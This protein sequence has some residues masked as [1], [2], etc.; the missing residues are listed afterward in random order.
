MSLR[1]SST[2]VAGL[3][4]AGL[5]IG[6]A[7]EGDASATEAGRN[8][9][10]SGLNGTMVGN[11]PPP[12]FY[13][14]NEFIYQHASRFNDSQGNKL[15]PDFSV[16]AAGYAP[17]FL[18]NSGAKLFGGDVAIQVIQPFLYTEVKNPS[19][20]PFV[21][22]TP[23]FGSDN[24]FALGDLFLTPVIGWHANNF[25]WAVGMD[26]VLPTGDYDKDRL[27]NAGQ[28][29][30]TL[31][32][33]IAFTY[34]PIEPLELST[35]LTWDH[36]FENNATEYASG[37]AFLVDYAANYYVPTSIGQIAPGL[38]GY[39]FKQVEDDQI[40]GVKF[41]DGFRGQ[42]FAIGP[43]V[44]LKHAS[45]AIGELKFQKEFEVE[46]RPAGERIFARLL[47]RF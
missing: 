25:H 46:N 12:G 1:F 5:F 28:N 32:P 2:L 24:R 43:Q 38:G 36:Y 18:W 40:S 17:R 41:Q 31:S 13:L 16:T 37:D 22:N 45:G 27:A 15:F 8:P 3:F 42:A 19:P 34:F 14:V 26:I 6:I 7:I 29:I 47:V 4:S 10:P 23:P 44:V 35:K 21:P 9:F 20:S 39:F 30:F 11:L 33:A